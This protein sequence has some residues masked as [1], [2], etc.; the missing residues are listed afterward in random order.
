MEKFNKN[1]ILI[2]KAMEYINTVCTKQKRFLSEDNM[3]SAYTSVFG[4][5]A[6]PEDVFLDLYRNYK[7]SVN[8]VEGNKYANIPS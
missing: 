2:H 8:V 7:C 3:F 1:G 6:I 5:E 4:K